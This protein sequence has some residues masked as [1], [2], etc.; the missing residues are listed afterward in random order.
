MPR[1]TQRGVDSRPALQVTANVAANEG[2][3]AYVGGTT[4]KVTVRGSTLALNSAALSNGGGMSLDGIAS[5]TVVDSS[6]FG[7]SAAQDG[8]ALHLRDVAEAAILGSQAAGNRRAMNKKQPP[9]SC[10]AADDYQRPLKC[11]SEHPSSAC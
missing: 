7:N 9:R 5:L 3:G 11:V 6:L 10:S 2:G 1:L 4:A 8:G